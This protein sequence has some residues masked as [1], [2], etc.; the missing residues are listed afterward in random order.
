[1]GGTD[2]LKGF[3]YQITYSVLRIIELLIQ[4][5][6]DSNEII[7]ESLNEKEEDF[8][9]IEDSKKEFI[10]IKK[11][12]EGNHWTLFDIKEIFTKFSQKGDDSTTF[13]FVTNGTGN[14]EVII[15]KKALA[16]NLKLDD[17]LLNKITPKG[18][19]RKELLEL[20]KSVKISTRY[21]IS[22]DD[23]DPAK[24]LRNEC[25]KLLNKYPFFCNGKDLK[26][27]YNSIWKLVF[28]YARDGKRVD[29]GTLKNEFEQIGLKIES[30]PWSTKIQID[31]FTGRIDEI[32][33]LTEILNTNRIICINGI[34]GI[35]KTWTTLKLLNETNSL[36]KMCWIGINQWTSIDNIQFT[37][38]S[39]LHSTNKTF[40]ANKVSTQERVQKIPAIVQSLN[41][42]EYILVFDSMNSSNDE[43]KSFVE[44]LI[45]SSVS[46]EIAGKIILSST[47]TIFN[48]RTQ[49]EKSNYQEF[50]LTGFE[51]E[52]TKFILSELSDNFSDDEISK[53]HNSIGGH[54]MSIFFL[55]DLHSKKGLNKVS[56]NELSEKSIEECRDYILEKSIMTLDEEDR[57]NLLSLSIFKGEIDWEQC[58]A[59]INSI[60]N[61][62]T[63][64]SSI[65]H[66]RLLL[67]TE[68]G[69][70]IHDSIRAV[71]QAI[72]SI[73]SK[74]EFLNKAINHIFNKM[75][76]R[77]NGP[78]GSVY[79]DD[80]IKWCDLL[81]ELN[82][83]HPIDEKY[84]IIFEL[85]E[86]ELDALWAIRRY[87]YP[88]DY[89]TEDLSSSQKLVNDLIDKGYVK[90]NDNPIR[91]K[92]EYELT[93]DL[94]NL[95]YWQECLITAL[96]LSKG[97]SNHMGYI[98]VFV[99][100]HAYA[101]Q[102]QVCWWEHC[103]E[104]M[105]LPPLPKSDRL[106]HQKF[107]KDK[108]ENGDYKDK[109]E[110]QLEFLLRI[111]NEKIPDD[112]PNEK[113]IE[114][115]E[116]SCPTFGHCCPG[117]KE[118]AQACRSQEQ[119]NE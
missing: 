41:E 85:S 71:C 97:I 98:P 47:E 62:K 79:Y 22:D 11:R 89:Q 111:I 65:F 99:E 87:G 24:V 18:K 15:L 68:S 21:G 59:Q 26:L 39:F 84:K 72:I 93:Y 73:P 101:E 106:E 49:E 94:N 50:D 102:M 51:L 104:F 16:S 17:T 34:N 60:L 12:I 8:N 27:V 80:M 70:L 81:S 63:A 54:P 46:N 78:E 103:I 33:G 57:N 36:E 35:G 91:K 114:M 108:F 29:L 113:D 86:L 45:Q 118:Q 23:E 96:C 95:N 66:K 4:N 3:D 69:I 25:F 92:Y 107:V 44:E 109:T 32:E 119:E 61:S 5:A 52:E 31:E 7:F 30:S 53:F 77:L 28:D 74:T 2:G 64:L 110:D 116:S 82:S 42:Y 75:E 13:H 37:I 20:L 14:P 83:I 58:D 40:L 1:M 6:P 67:K 10:Q 38:A 56:L 117:G 90:E 76:S 19:T 55:K 48:P 105:P 9:I 100:N 88:F 43:V 115:E 112:A